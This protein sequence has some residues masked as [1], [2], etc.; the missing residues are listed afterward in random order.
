MTNGVLQGSIRFNPF[1]SLNVPLGN[2]IRRHDTNFHSYADDTQ[3]YIAV[4]PDDTCFIDALLNCIF[5][6]K[7]WMADTFF[8]L[9][10]DTTEV[11]KAT[12]SY[13]H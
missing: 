6:I 1:L 12:L 7:I 11:Q 8:Q 2:F 9:N 5:D 4:S 3:L 13:T 10:Q